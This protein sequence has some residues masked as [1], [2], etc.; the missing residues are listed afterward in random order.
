V[1]NVAV[2]GGVLAA[3]QP[4]EFAA[5]WAFILEP[6]AASRTRLIER[7]RVS[8]G[9]TDKPWTALTLPVI[10][11]GVFLMTREQMLG[12]KDRAEGLARERLV[13]PAGQGDLPARATEGVTATVPAASN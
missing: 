8:F 3:T 1:A 7:F 2:T 9:E 10:G 12:I 13:P 6:I 11:F 5:S 4:A